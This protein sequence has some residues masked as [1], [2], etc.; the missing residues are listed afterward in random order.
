MRQQDAVLKHLRTDIEQKLQERNFE[1][2]RL[3]RELSLMGGVLDAYK[4]NLKQTK[5]EF[6]EY[7]QK[8]QYYKKIKQEEEHFVSQFKK[9]MEKINFLDTKLTG[10]GAKA[11][12]LHKLHA[13]RKSLPTEDKAPDGT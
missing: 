13:K 4:K 2:N 6:E 8:A 11:K 12:E 10:L 5:R 7:K 1:I 3:E 9:Y